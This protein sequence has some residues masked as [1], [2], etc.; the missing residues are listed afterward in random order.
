MFMGIEYIDPMSCSYYLSPSLV[1]STQSDGVCLRCGV[2]ILHHDRSMVR[3]KHEAITD[4][5]HVLELRSRR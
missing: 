4:H 3:S 5:V 2:I 1:D